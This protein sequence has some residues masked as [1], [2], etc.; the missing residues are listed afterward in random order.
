MHL[1]LEK[2]N[3]F[4]LFLHFLVPRNNVK[5][6]KNVH[7]AQYRRN[8]TKHDSRIR[9]KLPSLMQ[10]IQRRDCSQPRGF[11]LD[12]TYF[13]GNDAFSPPPSLFLF[14]SFFTFTCRFFLCVH[15][16]LRRRCRASFFT[17]QIRVN[18]RKVVI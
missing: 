14:S 18:K 6:N 2:Y 4:F 5:K 11:K 16:W 10:R 17:I 8:D 7:G 15:R 12:T 1:L 9:D 3:F 13:K